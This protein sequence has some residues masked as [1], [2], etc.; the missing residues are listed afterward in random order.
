MKK[1]RL[2]KSEMHGG[3][4]NLGTVVSASMSA[5]EG[6]YRSTQLERR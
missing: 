3:L 5:E 4:P 2:K 1:P 6:R